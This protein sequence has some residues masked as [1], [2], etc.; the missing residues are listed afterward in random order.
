M[1]VVMVMHWPEVSKEQ[2]EQARDMVQWDRDFAQG[3]R[4]HVSWMDDGLHVI[5]VWDKPEDF[6]TFVANRLTPAVQQIGIEGQPKVEFRDALGVVIP[7][8]Y[9]A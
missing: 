9:S 5:D 8:A 2:Y 4:A 6:Q 7:A 3:G 1:P